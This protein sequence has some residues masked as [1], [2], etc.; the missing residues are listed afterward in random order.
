MGLIALA[1]VFAIVLPPISGGTPDI[2]YAP[3][4]ILGVAVVF[5]GLLIRTGQ[6]GTRLRG[7]PSILSDS[8]PTGDRTPDDC[9]KL[10]MIY[11]NPADPALVIEKRFGIGWTLNFANRWAWVMT[12]AVVCFPILIRYVTT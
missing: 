9:W 11:Y 2:P 5:V 7:A 12:A 1:Y 8:S 10:G 3:F 4:L 6:G